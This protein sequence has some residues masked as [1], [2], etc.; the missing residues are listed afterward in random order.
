MN[1]TIGDPNKSGTYLLPMLE[2]FDHD[3]KGT[4][5]PKNCFRNC[6]LGDHSIPNK[7]RHLFLLYRYS[8]S[9]AYQEFDA[10]LQKHPMF[11]SMYDPDKYH[12]MYV[13]H[14][15]DDKYDDYMK[16]KEGHYS[17]F[18][19][20]HKQRIMTF[21]GLDPIKN[22]TNP[23]VGTLYRLESGY[24]H[25]ESFIN[26]DIPETHSKYLVK[27]PRDQ[28][29]SSMPEL[30][31]GKETRFIE[32]YQPKLRIIDVMDKIAESA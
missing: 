23:I 1:W 26:K 9:P 19:D 15:P 7:D 24:A 27:I 29:C 22:V 13:F 16:L 3:F 12:V 32:I 6:F 20:V 25:T 18:S 11:D 21:F 4:L 14:I 10:H 31:V 2:G 8:G 17:K 28:E 5:P 30:I